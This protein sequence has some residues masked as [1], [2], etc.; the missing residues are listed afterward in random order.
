MTQLSSWMITCISNWISKI[1]ALAFSEVF[2]SEGTIFSK[3]M[4]ERSIRISV[5][6]LPGV[7]SLSLRL[8][9][10]LLQGRRDREVGDR[11]DLGQ[12]GRSLG[13]RQGAPLLKNFRIVLNLDLK[14]SLSSQYYFIVRWS[15]TRGCRYW[16]AIFLPILFFSAYF[17]P[18]QYI[19]V[20]IFIAFHFNRT[21]PPWLASWRSLHCWRKSV[22]ERRRRRD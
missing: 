2:T 10:E 14:K 20:S 15:Y 9:D 8:L 12:L 17:A 19:W 22:Q 16:T 1:A 3:W 6:L 5:G 21:E 7:V 11:R 4:T 13:G 18:K